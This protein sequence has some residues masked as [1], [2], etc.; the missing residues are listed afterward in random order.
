M[1]SSRAVLPL[2]IPQH[3]EVSEERFNDLSNKQSTGKYRRQMMV[4]SD[5][6]TPMILKI[7][8]ITFCGPL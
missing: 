3:W 8:T 7:A 1:T 5:Y 2:T 6:S 4:I